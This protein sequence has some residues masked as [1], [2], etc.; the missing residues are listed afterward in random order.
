MTA[1]P[2][3]RRW[4]IEVHID[5]DAEEGLTLVEARLRTETSPTSCSRRCRTTSST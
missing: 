5:E 3:S 1:M 2:T 4:S